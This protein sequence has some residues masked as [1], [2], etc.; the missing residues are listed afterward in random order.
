M[1]TGPALRTV[2]SGMHATRADET[3]LADRLASD[4]GVARVYRLRSVALSGGVDALI[5]AA[6]LLGVAGGVWDVESRFL[7]LALLFLGLNA[8]AAAFV[9][10][11]A[12]RLEREHLAAQRAGDRG[13][14]RLTAS[15]EAALLARERRIRLALVGGSAALSVTMAVMLIAV[16]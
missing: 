3:A 16:S 9:P 8:A 13:A 4:D 14:E 1:A 2:R 5:W 12:R 10:G 7:P 6:A 15:A 11:E